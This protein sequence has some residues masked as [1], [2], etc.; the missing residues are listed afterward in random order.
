MA[1][2]VVEVNRRGCGVDVSSCA[3]TDRNISFWARKAPDGRYL[4][5]VLFD[6][7]VQH[8]PRCQFMERG[9]CAGPVRHA[10]IEPDKAQP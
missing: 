6:R 5:L 8:G 7:N 4:L 2:R 9:V 10:S 1:Q 3:A